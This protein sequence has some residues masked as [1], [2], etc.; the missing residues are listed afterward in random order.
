MEKVIEFNGVR[1]VAIP[2]LG[3]GCVGCAN[4]CEDLNPELKGLCTSYENTL[5]GIGESDYC[6]TKGIVW[7]KTE[8]QPLTTPTSIPSPT[9][10]VKAYNTSDYSLDGDNFSPK[11]KP[12]AD[13]QA[14]VKYDTDKIRYSLVPAFALQEVAR[15]L[16]VALKKYPAANN[17]QMVDNAEERYM[18][19]LMRH[20]EAV[21]RGEVYDTDNIDPTLSHMSA[22]AVNALFLLEFMLN[23]KLKKEGK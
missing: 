17:W 13:V 22:V 2:N 23:P 3:K 19:A 15:N 5:F 1:L 4:S 8:D 14:G 18:D 7:V 10:A 21:R 9:Q 16:T 11:Q 20:L 12:K 6:A